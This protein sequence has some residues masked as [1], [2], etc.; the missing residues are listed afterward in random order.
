MSAEDMVTLQERMVHLVEQLGMPLIEVSLVIG[1]WTNGLSQELHKVYSEQ[2]LEI[3]DF[4]STKWHIEESIAHSGNEFSL[5]KA[6]SVVD[7]DR[8]DILDTLIEATLAE[9]EL[10]LQDALIVLRGWEQLVRQALTT[11][12]SAGQL[13]SPLEIPE[14]F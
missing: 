11:T 3:P 6:L 7:D 4:L 1:R 14:D 13:F 12:S 10:N 5:E 9:L 2:G 8:I